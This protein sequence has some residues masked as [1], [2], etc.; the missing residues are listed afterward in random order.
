MSGLYHFEGLDEHSV[1]QPCRIEWAGSVDLLTCSEGSTG[2]TLFTQV[3]DGLS[4]RLRRTED[5]PLTLNYLSVLSPQFC[6]GNNLPSRDNDGNVIFDSRLS[7]TT[8]GN[9]F[10]CL[11]LGIWNN[12][13]LTTL[14][15]G[16]TDNFVQSR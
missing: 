11:G 15:D 3:D 10:A 13:W 2:P 6:G 14:D 4:T 7:L 5:N 12:L 8:R 16:T 9:S 1:W